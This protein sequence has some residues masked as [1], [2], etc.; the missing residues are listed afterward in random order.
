MPHASGEEVWNVIRAQRPD[1][2]VLFCTG[3]S[4]ASLDSTGPAS[5]DV[6]VLQKPFT[7]VEL[8]QRVRELLH[9]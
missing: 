2:R 7:S 5:G 6:S 9:R 3:Y 8:L 1:A 4:A